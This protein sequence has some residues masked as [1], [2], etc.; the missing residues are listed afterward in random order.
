MSEHTPIERAIA[1]CD[2]Q[3]GL[4]D[5]IGVSQAL[6]SQWL[7]GAL[8]H[9]RHF[10]GIVAATGGLVTAA[11]LLEFELAKLEKQNGRKRRA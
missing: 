7:S 1:I 4:A 9:Q 6:I 11:E 8:V 5:R 10:P 2:S 3:Q